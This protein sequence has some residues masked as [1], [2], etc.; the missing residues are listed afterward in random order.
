[1]GKWIADL[2]L[3]AVS[4]F[5]AYC[6]CIAVER[7]QIANMIVVVTVMLGLLTTM[8]DFTPV[9]KRWSARV[10]SLQQTADRVASIGQVQW[11]IPMK[12]EITQGY[13]GELHHGIDI[14]APEGTSV[15]ATREGDVSHVGWHDIYG[16]VVI[17]DHEKGMQ[18]VY[19]HL[20]GIAVKPGWPVLSGK[21]I[22]SCGSTGRSSGPH[23]HF[24]IRKNG[25]TVDPMSFL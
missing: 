23:L 12:G 7:K 20:K 4:G 16:N 11:E 25:T 1:M 8:Q 6:I 15:K 10:D 17:V 19:A 2:L 21:E 5:V 3:I 13:K 14:A 18:S 24:E 22:G 9:I